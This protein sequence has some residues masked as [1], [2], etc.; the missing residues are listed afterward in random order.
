[1]KVTR[2][3]CAGK[4]RNMDISGVV[5]LTCL[6]HGCFF[7]RAVVDLVGNE[8]FHLI[9]LAMFGAVECAMKLLEW[10]LSY[11]VGCTYLA[12][13]LSQ[14]EEWDLPPEMR[15]IV[16]SIKTLLPQMHMLSHKED[17]QVDFT[18]CY[19]HVRR[20]RP[21]KWRNVASRYRRSS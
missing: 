4:F 8:Q 6:C 20:W 16:E 10:L 12:N 11:N 19:K 3:Q 18:M 21:R 14:W 5:A 15:R 2:S 9:D 7:P 1:F 17:C 13:M